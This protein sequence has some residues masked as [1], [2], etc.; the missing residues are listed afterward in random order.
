MT[1][2]FYKMGL[3]TFR[4]ILHNLI[5]LSKLNI[6]LALLMT[7]LPTTQCYLCQNGLTTEQNGFY[8]IK[9]DIYDP[10][11]IYDIYKIVWGPCVAANNAQ[12]GRMVNQ[13]NVYQDIS[14]RYIEKVYQ[15][16]KVCESVQF[17][18]ELLCNMT[19][20]DENSINVWKIWGDKY[21][22][23]NICKGNNI[24]NRSDINRS[25]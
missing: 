13:D 8:N 24:Y 17:N 12:H 1:A 9:S 5:S 7:L 2:Q 23:T 16:Y 19:I 18:L 10:T 11:D 21:K 22:G 3:R 4:F 25:I 14:R 20:Q 15:E 6:V